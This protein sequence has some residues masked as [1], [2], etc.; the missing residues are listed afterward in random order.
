MDSEQ[1]TH[2]P[3]EKQLLNALGELADST[4]FCTSGTCPL[5]LPGLVVN[6][7][8]EVSL[9]VSAREARR[10]VKHASQAPYGRGEETIVDTQ[11]R[12]VWQLAPTQFRLENPKWDAFIT[13]VVRSVK[14]EFAVKQKVTASLYKLLIYDKGSFFV[15]HRDTEKAHRMF[16]TLVI[17]LPSHHEG[18][19]LIVSHAGQS[20]EIDFSGKMSSY[21]LQYAA[22]YADCQH[23][24][25]PVTDGYRVCLVYNLATTVRK[26]QPAAPLFAT[27][28]ESASNAIKAMFEEDDER[29]MIVLPLLHQ[30]TEAGLAPD[31]MGDS[32]EDWDDDEAGDEWGDQDEQDFYDQA[33]EEADD[34]DEEDWN[35][36][37]PARKAAQHVSQQS[38]D[39]DLPQ[40]PINLEFKGGDRAR[41]DVLGQVA[42][43]TGCRAFVAL[44]T[45]WQ[46][47]NPDYGTI[48]YAPYGNSW[49]YGDDQ[50]VSGEN[51]RAEFEEVHDE[52]ISLK[53]WHSLTGEPQPFDE[54]SLSESDIVSDIPDEDRPYR[55]ELHEATGNAGMSMERWYH[56]AVVVLWPE[57]R[58]YHVLASQGAKNS[59]PALLA[60]VESTSDPGKSE[61]C[62][63]F[64]QRILDE[65]SYPTHHCDHPADS[66]GTKML[67]CVLATNDSRLATRFFEVVLP[68]EYASL[69]R[70]SLTSLAELATWKSIERPLT[71]L[72]RKQ[73]PDDYRAS[74][75]GLVST[76]GTLASRGGALS[77]N[78]KSV[79]KAVLPEVTEL[80]A[81]WEKRR[82]TIGS[83]PFA[84]VV[85]P[86]VRG[87]CA[88]GARN[89]VK[90]LLSQVA[91]KP[92][93]YDLHSVV[94]PAF[95]NL[96]SDDEFAESS[97]LAQTAV[98][99]LGQFCI[100]QLQQR[101]AKKPQPPKNWKRSARVDCDCEDCR[102]LVSF[103]KDKD[104]KVHRF[105]RRKDLRQHLH[106]QID[107]YRLDCA[108]VTE[109]V[110]RPYTLVCTKNQ[111]TYQRNLKQYETDCELLQELSSG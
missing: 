8:G 54:L 5:V 45:H 94:I 53:H 105:P 40:S 64:A 1:R 55:Q 86:L 2:S 108:H 67:Q 17:C 16:A 83:N 68:Q 111:A 14:S 32:G 101:T 59:V 107:S 50:D 70:D 77:S 92:K 89:D 91:A 96:R 38:P 7:V 63:T 76:F 110:G 9:P 102:E 13:D 65:W 98:R 106:Q 90:Q 49:G 18:G 41:V 39:T 20:R 26:Q 78:R 46:S 61:D 52:T 84:G 97:T 93:H 71:S 58:H 48:D 66:L 85:D 100:Q 21:D 57:S 43:R 80:V 22:F 27:S 33:Q 69:E 42:A 81:R 103:L 60:L 25:R 88:V 44:L 3:A 15:P 12:R 99:E 95:R 82:P 30:Y 23:E 35:D 37:T 75:R 62:K 10:L 29:D 87:I 73:D 56:Q 109:R 24:V 19:T 36:D 34:A 104:A 28:V 72:F 79:C 31:P 6:G 51:E 11:V 4:S 74:L 47:G